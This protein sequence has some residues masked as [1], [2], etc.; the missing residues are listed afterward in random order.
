MKA[1]RLFLE[2]Q[3]VERETER[4]EFSKEIEQLRIILKDRDKDKAS[5]DNF[6]KEVNF[7]LLSSF[8]VGDFTILCSS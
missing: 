2:D 1:T 7:V 5:Q 6:Q 8:F 4:D 3:A